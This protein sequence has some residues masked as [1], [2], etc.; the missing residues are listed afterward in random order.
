MGIELS[1]GGGL[2]YDFRSM[3]TR[4]LGIATCLC[5]GLTAGRACGEEPGT[6]E[7]W[8]QY[9]GAAGDGLA[10]G[11]TLPTTWGETEKV[12]WRTAVP[13]WGWSSPIVWG[14]RVFVTSAVSKTEL[15]VPHVGGYP[16]GHVGSEEEHRWMLYCLDFESG[17]IL[18][19]KETHRGVPPQQRHPRN[20]F[21]RATW[22]GNYRKNFTWY[23]VTG[24]NLGKLEP[25]SYEISWIEKP[26]VFREFVDPK[27]RRNSWPGDVR[28][29]GEPVR[30]GI[31]VT[32]RE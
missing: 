3:E 24:V 2:G 16:G 29:N 10:T 6:P 23:S 8:P 14:D 26:Y 27:D 31:A 1:R 15:P 12:V 32:V 28:E 4:L 7:N 18:W 17:K 25:G 5:L 19:E 11:E 21:A 20:S 9:R 22:E 30:S 13:G